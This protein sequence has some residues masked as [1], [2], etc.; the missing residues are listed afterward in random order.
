MDCR[1]RD[2][3]A[4]VLPKLDR[5][6]IL[7]ALKIHDSPYLQAPSIYIQWRFNRAQ[8]RVL[9]K[10]ILYDPLKLQFVC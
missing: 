2:D 9:L 3:P 7:F 6:Y 10:A 5:N 1:E 4:E 8:S